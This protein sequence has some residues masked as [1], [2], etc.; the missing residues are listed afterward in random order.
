[1][2]VGDIGLAIG[3][4]G[5]MTELVQSVVL[6]W[7]D[8]ESNMTSVERVLEY[9]II[10]QEKDTGK[11]EENWPIKG[12]VAFENVTLRY[13]SA[14][15]PVLENISFVIGDG[16]KIGIVGRTGAGKSSI[17]SVLQRLYE[18]DGEVIID[19]INTETVSLNYLR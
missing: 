3:Q 5:I 2:T 6:Y 13:E 10:E 19:H 4:V 12:D 18:Y 1:M 9:T 17:I 16:Q 15:K 14:A 8:L 11:I 7:A